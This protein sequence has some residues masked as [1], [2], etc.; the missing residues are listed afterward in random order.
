VPGD[1]VTVGLKPPTEAGVALQGTCPSGAT[2]QITSSSATDGDGYATACPSFTPSDSTTDISVQKVPVRSLTVTGPADRPGLFG[3]AILSAPPGGSNVTRTVCTDLTKACTATFPAGGNVI[4]GFKPPS[5]GT[6]V[7]TCPGTGSAFT[8][9]AASYTD[10]SGYH[11]PCP[12][13]ITPTVN[14]TTLSVQYVAPP[15]PP[16]PPSTVTVTV[17]GPCY[18]VSCDDTQLAYA[19]GVKVGDSVCTN[20]AVACSATVAAGSPIRIGIQPPTGSPGG[21]NVFPGACPGGGG[22][23][24]I[25]TLSGP[26]EGGY[27]FEPCLTFTP[28]ANTTIS[29]GRS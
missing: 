18:G 2:F 16:P 6:L 7:G 22:G 23:F 26:L 15:P 13:S 12:Q 1:T 29:V 3:I 24:S 27:V 11:F 19:Y 14:S 8:V 5:E 9:T 21:W 20:S 17:T 10:D 28:G 4:A 25:T